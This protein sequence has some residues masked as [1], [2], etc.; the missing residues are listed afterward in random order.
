[1]SEQMIGPGRVTVD[2]ASHRFA[3]ARSDAAQAF[4]KV[5]ADNG[6]SLLWPGQAVVDGEWLVDL[7]RLQSE[8]A[9]LRER[10]APGNVLGM[11][12]RHIAEHVAALPTTDHRST[13]K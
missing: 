11:A 4:L 3:I 9:T 7:L 5:M 10:E 8:Y 6:F 2:P 13:R 1:M 12:L